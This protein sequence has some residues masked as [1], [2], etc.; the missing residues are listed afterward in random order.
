MPFYTRRGSIV[1]KRVACFDK[2]TGK[3]L[4]RIICIDTSR[5]IALQLNTEVVEEASTTKHVSVKPVRRQDVGHGIG[6]ELQP[7]EGNGVSISRRCQ[8]VSV[9]TILR[10]NFYVKDRKTGEINPPSDVAPQLPENYEFD[11]NEENSRPELW[12]AELDQNLREDLH[13]NPELRM[14]ILKEECASAI[15]SCAKLESSKMRQL[16]VTPY[17]NEKALKLYNAKL[18]STVLEYLHG[19]NG[20]FVFPPPHYTFANR[21]LAARQGLGI[22]VRAVVNSTIQEIDD[23]L[24]EYGKKGYERKCSLV[25]YAAKQV[26]LRGSAIPASLIERWAKVL[27]KLADKSIW[28]FGTLAVLAMPLDLWGDGTPFLP[29]LP[30]RTVAHLMD[31]NDPRK[32][33]SKHE[34][35]EISDDTIRQK[36]RRVLLLAY[37]GIHPEFNNVEDSQKRGEPYVDAT[38]E[39]INAIM[40]NALIVDEGSRGDDDWTNLP[41]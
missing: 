25:R 40:E 26:T 17:L 4:E 20:D 34:V 7:V 1:G 21:G 37:I 24:N 19:P 31:P 35:I 41:E 3:K 28:E 10:G 29:D 13:E 11:P 16:D 18:Q 9:K 39:A 6:V 5:G 15:E 36:G 38:T 27:N 30:E 2:D 14:D 12:D 22:P 33:E 8:R 32:I 23:E